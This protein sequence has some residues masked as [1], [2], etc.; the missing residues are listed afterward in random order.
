MS[1]ADVLGWCAAACVV[2]LYLPQVWRTRVH[3]L[4]H[5]VPASRAWVAVCC[6]IVWCGYGLAGGGLVQVVLNVVLIALNLLLLSALVR[7]LGAALPGLALVVGTTWAV[8][9]LAL[10]GGKDL[11][12]AAGAVSATVVYLPQALALRRPGAADGVSALSLQLQG[13][14][15]L[16]WV[17]YGGLR[18]E[19]VVWLP[20]LVV[21]GVTAW[22]LLLLRDRRTEPVLVPSLSASV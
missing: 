16:L 3:G 4:T 6:C 11:V 21:M 17:G 9:L 2:A 14:S 10:L 7:D 13:L 22:T 18:A 20:N 1:V 8:G 5:G 19:E 15:G 12:G